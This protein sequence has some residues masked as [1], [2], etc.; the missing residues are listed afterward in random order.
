VDNS[1]D[2]NARPACSKFPNVRY[3]HEPR[4]GLSV[5]RNTGL[6]AC[7]GE[8]IAFTDDDVE[9]H[10]RWTVEIAHAFATRDVDAI[11]GLILPA[12]LDTAAQRFFQ[13]TMGAFGTMFVP[14]VFERHFFEETRP[15]GAHVWKIGAGANMAFRRSVFERHGLF[16]ERLGAGAAGCSEDSELW[17]RLL[18][19][20]GSCLFEPR[21]AVFHHHRTDWKGLRR[22]IRHYMRGHVAALIVQYDSFHDRGSLVRIGKQLPLYFMKTAINLTLQSSPGRATILIE[23]MLGY[24]TGLH[25]AFRPGWRRRRASSLPTSSI[26]AGNGVAA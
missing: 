22:Q 1:K 12:R 26:A 2:A 25:Y 10:P 16:D 6:R 23:E 14:A 5:A 4:L 13:F 17:Y 18:A 3:I 19:G 20:G 7:S 11:T 15:G 24:A 8:L 9:L 21:V